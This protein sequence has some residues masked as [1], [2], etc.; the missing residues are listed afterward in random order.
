MVSGENDGIL[1]HRLKLNRV[2]PKEDNPVGI[3]SNLLGNVCILLGNNNYADCAVG[4]Q[5]STIIEELCQALFVLQRLYVTD[6]IVKDKENVLVSIIQLLLGLE[7]LHEEPLDLICVSNNLV[8][9]G[10]Y[11]S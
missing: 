3:A 5:V 9:L 4:H 8:D 2:E 11:P 10:V 1:P 7:R 6:N